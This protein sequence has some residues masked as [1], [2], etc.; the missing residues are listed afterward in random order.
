MM[1]AISFADAAGLIYVQNT[2]S[3]NRAC[4][5]ADAGIVGRLGATFNLGL[6]EAVSNRDKR[7]TVNFVFVHPAL[8]KLF[9]ITPHFQSQRLDSML[10]TEVLFQPVISRE[11]G[12]YNMGSCSPGDVTAENPEMW[13]NNSSAAESITIVSEALDAHCAVYRFSEGVREDFAGVGVFRRR[14]VSRFRRGVADARDNRSR[15]PHYG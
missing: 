5:S 13:T 12:S 1:S 7:E 14:A 10:P 15:Y 11:H 2:V 3:G 9:G 8:L 4:G 6:G